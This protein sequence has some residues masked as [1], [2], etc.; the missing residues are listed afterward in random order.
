MIFNDFTVAIF[1]SYCLIN[2]VNKPLQNIVAYNKQHL[3]LI[4][5]DLWIGWGGYPPSCEMAGQ[6]C[7]F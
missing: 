7:R 3:N 5:T 6:S 1:V 4:I 2:V